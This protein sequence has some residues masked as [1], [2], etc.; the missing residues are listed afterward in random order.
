MSDQPSVIIEQLLINT[1][2]VQA[3]VQSE[4][5]RPFDVVLHAEVWDEEKWEQV[6]ALLTN[7]ASYIA[8]L[9]ND[10]WPSNLTRKLAANGL[11][12]DI[13]STFTHQTCP[14]TDDREK[15]AGAINDST[16]PQRFPSTGDSEKRT[17]TIN[18][19]DSFEPQRCVHIQ[20][21]EEA[22]AQ[23]IHAKPLLLFKLKGMEEQA[24]FSELR[25]RRSDAGLTDSTDSGIHL[26]AEP[27]KSY[28]ESNE[29]MA[30]LLPEQSGPLFWR[31]E[32]SLYTV[33]RP[34]YRK[35]SERAKN[36]QRRYGLIDGRNE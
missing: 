30:R 35:V 24:L 8:S 29:P 12:S 22:L 14:C 10:Q 5:A 33:M 25:N 27:Y 28:V 34:V 20:A 4:R 32:V 18:V 13:R 16:E 36:I 15:R 31:K 2:E 17:G 19:N 23:R 11:S 3:R 7:E 26:Q 1:G 6:L 9:L 21:V